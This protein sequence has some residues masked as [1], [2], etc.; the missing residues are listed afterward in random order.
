MIQQVRPAIVP[1]L[2]ILY[3]DHTAWFFR[4]KSNEGQ[5]E[6]IPTSSRLGKLEEG[7]SYRAGSRTTAFNVTRRISQTLAEMTSSSSLSSTSQLFKCDMLRLISTKLTPAPP[8]LA[9]IIPTKAVD[10]SLVPVSTILHRRSSN[11]DS[12]TCLDECFFFEAS[13]CALDAFWNLRSRSA[14]IAD[15]GVVMIRDTI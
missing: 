3:L 7:K 15:R 13:A 10:P 4:W 14:T 2:L 1:F 6:A 8:P 12:L 9:H 11:L 5:A